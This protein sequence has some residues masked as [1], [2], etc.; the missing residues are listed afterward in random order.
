MI[1]FKSHHALTGFALWLGAL[2]ATASCA[3]ENHV[4]T[5]PF[6]NSNFEQGD[7]SS[8]SVKG[9]A[10]SQQPTRGDNSQTRGR[11]S[12]Q[13]AGEY[14][15]GGFERCTKTIGAPGEIGGDEPVGELLSPKFTV[16]KRYLSFLVGGGQ[17]PGQLGVKLICAGQE[18]ELATGVDSESMVR[19]NADVSKFL[20]QEARLVIYDNATG[21]WGH[22]N[23]DDFVATDQPIPDS[24]QEFVI[25]TDLAADGYS[26]IDY[27][28]PLR[29]QFHFTSGRNWLNDPNGMVYDGKKYH[30]FFQHNPAAPVWGNMT[31]GHATSPDMV[32]WTQHPH[33]LL[34]YRVE[35]RSGTI[36]SGTAVVDHNNSLGMQKGEQK[37]LCAFFTFATHPKFYQ[38]LAYSTDGGAT[39]TYW[40]EGRPVV[41]NQSEQG[42][43]PEQRDPKVFWHEPSQRWV[44][45]L[46]VQS[47]PGRVRFFTSQNLTD[48]TF[49]SDL[50]RDWAFECMDL[51]FVPAEGGGGEHQA[52]L[53]DASFDYEIGTFDGTEFHTTAGPFHAGGGNYYAAQT[54]NNA[55]KGR[56]VQIG[57]MRG[58]PNAAERYG[59]PY[60][61]QMGFPYELT[62]KSVDSQPKL[63]AW[64]IAELDTLVASSI[65]SRSQTVGS[66]GI[67]LTSELVAADLMDIEVAFDPGSAEAIHL[68]FGAAHLRYL[69][70]QHELWMTVAD[71]W[72]DSQEVLVFDNLAPRDGAIA[73]RLLVDRLSVE[74]FAFG[75]ERFYAGY[76]PPLQSSAH[77]EAKAIGGEA[78]ISSLEV[79]KL[80]SAWRK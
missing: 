41:P 21:T 68:E 49:A 17:Q 80:R 2:S 35:G 52:V 5:L 40:N 46:W 69:N 33:A 10:F 9:E 30:L 67:D 48:W 73:L 59:L 36:F 63:F 51:F 32:H 56:N 50:M 45:V 14:W 27:S 53:Y 61:Q 54:F 31:W 42:F 57:W 4:A 77:I 15:V 44:M 78:I 20:G 34:P 70:Q 19:C 71:D 24:S 76:V 12:C 60:N 64:P 79:R 13:L 16:T 43:D 39:W 28:E 11:E 47:N 22:I 38:A 26:E 3:Q 62:V 74:V 72:G 65:T 55:P 18:Q 23:V 37:T 8:W 25:R 6:A 58:G 7:L 1:G 29:P 75:G 66:E